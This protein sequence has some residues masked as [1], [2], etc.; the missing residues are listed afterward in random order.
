MKLHIFFSVAIILLAY[1]HQPT[2]AQESRD[3]DCPI[4]IVSQLDLGSTGSTCTYKASIQNGDPSVTPKFKWTISNGKISGGQGTEE[5]SVEVEGDN[6]FTVTVEVTGYAANC[7]NKASHA[8]LIH[9]LPASKFDEYGDL[10]FSEEKLRLDRFAIQLHNEPGSKGYIIVY[11]ATE[12]RK[13][14]AAEHG[15]RAKNYLVKVSGLSE[16]QIV[17]VS[18]GQRNERL[19]ELFISP[20]GALPATAT[21]TRSPQ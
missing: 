7:Q 15:K 12:T 11:D 16:A 1:S 17:V 14:S 8:S 5:V 20:A 6:S 9:R 19:V 13:P 21:P 3:P 2:Q 18:G 10:E 4:I